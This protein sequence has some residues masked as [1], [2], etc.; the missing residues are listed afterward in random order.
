MDKN[1]LREFEEYGVKLGLYCDNY[2]S[3]NNLY[4]GLV[5]LEDNDEEEVCKGEHWADVT[6][7]I[8][9]LSPLEIA[10]NKDFEEFSSKK[11]FNEVIEYITDDSVDEYY[12]MPSGFTQFRVYN[13][14]GHLI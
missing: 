2:V 9:M 3:N 13:V 7:N 8:D 5:V 4:F 6:I 14:G 1:I 12:L 11:L 10:I